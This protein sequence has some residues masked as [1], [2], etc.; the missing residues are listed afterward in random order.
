MR[1]VPGT[2]FESES[3]LDLR[4]WVKAN[5][6]FL[7]NRI[8]DKCSARTRTKAMGSTLRWSTPSME[9]IVAPITLPTFNILSAAISFELRLH[10]NCRGIREA[11]IGCEMVMERSKH[12]GPHWRTPSRTATQ[13]KPRELCDLSL[14]NCLMFDPIVEFNPQQIKKRKCLKYQKVIPKINIK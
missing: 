11:I 9:P 1:R 2:F 4:H 12:Y 7:P 13:R 8:W 14:F 3:H 10:E 6:M 5:A